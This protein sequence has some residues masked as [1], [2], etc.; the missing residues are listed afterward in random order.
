MFVHQ[1][2]FGEAWEQVNEV[3]AEVGW[4]VRLLGAKGSQSQPEL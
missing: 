1:S 3:A 4:F 2:H